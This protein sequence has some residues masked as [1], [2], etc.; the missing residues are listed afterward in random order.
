MATSV[1][2]LP[3]DRTR[4]ITSE[5]F[6]GV[7]LS[8]MGEIPGTLEGLKDLFPE[9]SGDKISNGRGVDFSPKIGTIAGSFDKFGIPK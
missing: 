1:L 7:Q 2:L 6:S 4:P 8:A 5:R 3:L 9:R